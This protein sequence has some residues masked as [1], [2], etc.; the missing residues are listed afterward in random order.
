MKS[1]NMETERPHGCGGHVVLLKAEGIQFPEALPDNYRNKFD[2]IMFFLPLLIYIY[3]Y[4]F[5]GKITF[6]KWLCNGSFRY[7][8]S[9]GHNRSSNT[10]F[11][12]H[13]T[14]LFI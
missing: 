12:V 6:V 3:I 1:E 11:V 8:V 9:L 10:V 14:L 2:T 4:V 5:I 7:P 13:K